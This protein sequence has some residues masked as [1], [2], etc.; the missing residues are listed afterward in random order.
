MACARAACRRHG[1]SSHS[2]KLIVS[3]RRFNTVPKGV[4]SL[5][6]IGKATRVFLNVV[7]RANRTTVQHLQVPLHLSRNLSRRH[8]THAFDAAGFSSYRSCRVQRDLFLG[9]RSQS[10]Q[11]RE[12]DR[13]R[14][15]GR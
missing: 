11:Y 12:G 9:L 5:P 10:V 13:V 6:R 7:D 2:Q 8:A 1:S 4:Q 15:V 3:L 14:H